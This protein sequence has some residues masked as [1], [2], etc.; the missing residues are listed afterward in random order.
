MARAALAA[1]GR[2][3]DLRADLVALSRE[4]DVAADGAFLVPSEYVIVTARRLA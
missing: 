1:Q 3:D 2:W 4:M